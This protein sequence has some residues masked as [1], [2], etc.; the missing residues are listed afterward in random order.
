MVIACGFCQYIFTAISS[1]NKQKVSFLSRYLSLQN[2]KIF[3][4]SLKIYTF[5]VIITSDNTIICFDHG[6]FYLKGNKTSAGNSFCG[7]FK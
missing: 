3:V 2:H 6:L 4:H 1:F 5:K 7:P